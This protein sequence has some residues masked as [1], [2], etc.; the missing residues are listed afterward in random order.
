MDRS[1]DRAAAVV[2]A[3]GGSAPAVVYAWRQAGARYVV[4]GNRTTGSATALGQR[5]VGVGR[6]ARSAVA[7]D[8]PA[9]AAAL[10]SA[11]LAVNATT[12][13]MLDPGTTV[14]VELLPSDAT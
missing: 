4:G 6:G 11:D 9:F 2:A 3:A 13:G 5:F 7:L 10:G 14:A 1:L 12:V 8:D